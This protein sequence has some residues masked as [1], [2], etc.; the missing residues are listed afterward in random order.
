MESNYVDISSL[1][2]MMEESRKAVEGFNSTHGDIQPPMAIAQSK[3]VVKGNKAST[4]TLEDSIKQNDPKSIWSIEEIP[5][6]DAVAN[7]HDDRPCPRYEISYRQ[8]VGTQDAFL[9]INNISPASSDC[10]HLI[11][12]IHFPGSKMK[13]LDLDVTRERIR[14]ENKHLRLFT[15]LPVPVDKDSG[16][17]KFDTVKDVLIVTLPIIHDQF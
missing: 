3:V 9:G 15:F 13:D 10:T 12:K 14:A 1:S 16:S 7:Y 5:S 8:S 17:A 4:D 6:E 2:N 11:I